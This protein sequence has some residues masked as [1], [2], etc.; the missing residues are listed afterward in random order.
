MV[1]T[2]SLCSTTMRNS[3]IKA[4]VL[5]GYLQRLNFLGNALLVINKMILYFPILT[6][7]SLFFIKVSNPQL[8]IAQNL[9]QLFYRRYLKKVAR[10]LNSKQVPSP[11]SQLYN[12]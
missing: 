11:F 6:T 5:V 3:T 10:T 9:L 12:L 8:M 7:R 1:F 2:L 4:N